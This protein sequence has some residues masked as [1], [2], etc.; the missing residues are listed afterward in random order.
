MERGV[1]AVLT[2]VIVPFQVRLL[3]MEA[4]G[5]LSFVTSLQVLCNIL[6]L[7]LAPMIVREVAG[8]RDPERTHSAMIVQTFSAVYWTIASLL[9]VGLF[10]SSSWLARSWLRFDALPVASVVL[11][12]RLMAISIL[13]RWPISLYAGSIAGIQRLDVVNMIRIAASAVRLLGGLIVLVASRSLVAYLLWLGFVALL[14]VVSYVV[15]LM[16][17]MPLFSLKPRMS[18]SL[19]RKVWRYSIHM[20]VISV[21]S[22]VFVQSDRLIISRFLSVTELGYYSLAYNIVSGLSVIPTVL[23]TALFPQLAQ[24][25]SMGKTDQVRRRCDIA[26]QLLMYAVAGAAGVLIFFGRDILGWISAE[27]ARH[28]YQPMLLLLV[29][30]VL[31]AAIAVPYTLS[32]A[33][34][35]TRVPLLVNLAAVVVYVPFVY[36]LVKLWGITGA[37]CA[38]AALNTYYLIVM[39][40]LMQRRV[41][42]RS[43]P[44]WFGRNVMPFLICGLVLIGGAERMIGERDLAHTIAAAVIGCVLYGLAA[45]LFVDSSIRHHIRRWMGGEARLREAPL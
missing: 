41:P 6:D 16:R 28:A 3:G 34:G 4:Y 17:L 2:L 10:A 9:A 40:P 15:A 5:L 32:V 22:V 30:F 27:G 7:G 31:A 25:M 19:I 45:A 29:G 11:A 42:M 36:V 26:V 21:L 43:T 13:L 12:I 20:N 24:D 1:S 8:D 33:S 44:A 35:E 38:W 18:L 37:A 23:T 14:E 39:V